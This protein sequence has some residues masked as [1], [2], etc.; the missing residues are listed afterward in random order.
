MRVKSLAR[1][2][3]QKQGPARGKD[4]PLCSA[5][6]EIGLLVFGQAAAETKL[7]VSVLRDSCTRISLKIKI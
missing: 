5:D 1:A 4:L 7:K 2:A 3:A 6:L